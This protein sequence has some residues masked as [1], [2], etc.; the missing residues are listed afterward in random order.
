[1]ASAKTDIIIL[2]GITLKVLVS[3]FERSLR[4]FGSLRQ[5]L[6]GNPD[7]VLSKEKS[8]IFPLPPPLFMRIK[9]KKDSVF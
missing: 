6:K 2:L 4:V 7:D 3:H 8:R 5:V 9:R 1:M